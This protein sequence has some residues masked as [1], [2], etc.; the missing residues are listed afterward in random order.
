MMA[1][2]SLLVIQH[3]LSSKLAMALESFVKV[4]TDMRQTVDAG[5]NKTSFN[6]KEMLFATFNF[7]I[8]IPVAAIAEPPTPLMN[9]DE[10]GCRVTKSLFSGDICMVAPVSQ[11]NGRESR[12]FSGGFLSSSID[13]E[14]A[15]MSMGLL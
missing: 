5:T 3:F 13:V 10:I 2:V 12:E 14:M 15:A 7:T 1:P 4:W 6:V 11:K 8:P 9:R